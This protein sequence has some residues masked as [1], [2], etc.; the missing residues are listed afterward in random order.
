MD[1]VT[2]LVAIA[3]LKLRLELLERHPQ[4]L[5]VDMEIRR[6]MELA[7]LKSRLARAKKQEADISVT[8]RRFDQALDR[9]DELH[10]VAL[11]HVGQLEH[12]AEELRSMIEGMAGAGD[13]GGPNDGEPGSNGSEVG[14][15]ITSK[16][17]GQ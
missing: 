10:G 17:D 5:E 12:H 9:I 11:G 4:L 2:A 7:G 8:G 14:Q 3:H 1:R 6:P 15:V 16:V 13:N